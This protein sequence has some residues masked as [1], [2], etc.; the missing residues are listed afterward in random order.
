MTVTYRK[1]TI[2]DS[3]SVFH[4]FNASIT[5]YG[6]RMNVMAVTGGDD[7]GFLKSLWQKRKSM[8]EFLAQTASEFWVAERDGKVI[9]YA[10][11]VE[12]DGL[13]ELTE[14][15][16]LPGQQSGGVGGGLLSRAFPKT[17]ARYRTIIAT[18]DERALHRYMKAGVYG[19]FLLKYFHRKAEKVEVETD[20][21]VEPMLLN[22]H[23]ADLNRIDRKLI[24]HAREVVHEWIGTTRSGFVYKRSGEVVGYGYIGSNNGPFALLDDDDFPAAL[25][26]AES[27]NAEKGDD[28]GAVTP[29]IN[30]RAIR[31][32]TERNYRI[33]AF[34]ALFMS[35][36]LFGKFE[37]YLF[38][39]PEFFL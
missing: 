38:F 35:D 23:L 27:L 19:R 14:F 37:N 17:E 1:G 34:S 12:H 11:S 39:S 8:F 21:V 22:I 5:D 31:Y 29:L 33:D 6:E 36:A 20:L 10:R 25:A 15:F 7:P 3:E 24:G 4:V 13:Q 30:E 2:S 28:F 16:V 32:F 18:L 9:G 26:H